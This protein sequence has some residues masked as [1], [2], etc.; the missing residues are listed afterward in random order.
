MRSLTVPFVFAL[1]FSSAAMPQTQA[2]PSRDEL[3]RQQAAGQ[4]VSKIDELIALIDGAEREARLQCMKAFGH[5][6]FCEC[7]SHNIPVMFTF[8]EYV[9]ANTKTNE[10][11]NYSKLATDRR[12]AVDVARTARDVCVKVL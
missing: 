8:D 12:H 1:V 11:L 6:K 2:P 5:A 10:E 3:E 7:V 9:A 4:A